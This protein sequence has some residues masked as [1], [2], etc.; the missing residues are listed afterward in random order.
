MDK[1]LYA[2]KKQSQQ[3]AGNSLLFTDSAFRNGLKIISQQ[4]LAGAHGILFLPHTSG[5][6]PIRLP[7]Y[8]HCG[9]AQHNA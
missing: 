4:I 1:E 5:I 8:I 9:I 2:N 7:V 6:E 3:T